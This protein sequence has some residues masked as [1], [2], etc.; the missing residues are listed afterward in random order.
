MWTAL[1]V[2]KLSVRIARGSIW[3]DFPFP[4]VDGCV[5]EGGGA[6]EWGRE[7]LNKKSRPGPSRISVHP[8]FFAPKE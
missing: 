7:S 3:S 6:G 5:R 1:F 8:C 4:E 2:W